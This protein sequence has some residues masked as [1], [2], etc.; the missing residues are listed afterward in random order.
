VEEA[1]AV[2]VMTVAGERPMTPTY[3]IPDPTFMGLTL[4]DV[5]AGVEDW[6]PG[7]VTVVSVDTAPESD[8]VQRATITW[9]RDDEDVEV[10]LDD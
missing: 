6:G 5:A 2:L 9:A 7:G 10:D 8:S 3:G 1:L 4:S